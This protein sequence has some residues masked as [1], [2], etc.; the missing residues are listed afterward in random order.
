M[1]SWT[2]TTTETNGEYLTSGDLVVGIGNVNTK[3]FESAGS[4]TITWTT[5]PAN[6]FDLFNVFIYKIGATIFVDNF[7]G[8]SGTTNLN[9]AG[10]F[11][12]D[13]TAANLV[14]WSIT[15]DFTSSTEE[16][17]TPENGS[18]TADNTENNDSTTESEA[19]FYQVM[20]VP[21]FITLI[22]IAHK[23]RLRL[24]I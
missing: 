12:L 11:Y 23:N 5:T 8:E 4:A 16:E 13:V 21:G 1:E 15:V 18:Q 24:I 19:P 7:D 2:I 14:E 20:L 10:T 3:L 22:Y 6:D 17:N 9:S